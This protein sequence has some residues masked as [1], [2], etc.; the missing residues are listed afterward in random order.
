VARRSCSPARWSNLAVVGLVVTACTP[1]PQLNVP[2]QDATPPSALWLQANIPNQPLVNV[3]LG[4]SVATGEMSDTNHVSITA[5]ADDPDGGIKAIR[6]W[7]TTRRSMPGTIQGPTLAGAPEVEN[8]SSAAVGQPASPTESVTWEL[9]V[10]PRIGAFGDVSIDVFAEAENFHGGKVNTPVL[11]LHVRRVGLRLRVIALSNDDGTRAPQVTAAQFTDVVARVNRVYRG[12]GIRF[13]YDEAA[14]WQP[15]NSTGMNQDATIFADGN[16][17][18]A[19]LPGRIP[20]LLRWGS[21]PGV[22]GNGNAFPPPGAGTL[23]A[24]VTDNDQRY[25]ALPSLYPTTGLSFLTL[26]NGSFVAHE[27]GHYLG[28]YHTFPGWDGVNPVYGTSTGSAAVA[29]QALITYIGNNT[30]TIAALD[31]D[32]LADTPPDPGTIIYDLH[33]NSDGNPNE[34]CTTPQIT[35]TGTIGGN[36]VS[37]TFDPDV[38]NVMSYHAMCGTGDN[39]EPQKFTPDQVRQIHHVLTVPIRNHLLSPP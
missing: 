26:G 31:G 10:E 25:V 33:G 27:L 13:L 19:T 11:T 29:D 32:R 22:T 18:A 23:P 24:N 39:P 37:F 20:L 28:L 12:S 9:D 1:A 2:P 6:I 21:G 15:V 17:L 34:V 36:P 7:A 5:R 8:V 4:G 14:D 35:V 3:T 30:S 16:A 38:R